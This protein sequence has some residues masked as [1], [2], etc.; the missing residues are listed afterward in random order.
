MAQFKLHRWGTTMQEV[1]NITTIWHTKKLGT[2]WQRRKPSLQNYTHPSI[3]LEFGTNLCLGSISTGSLVEPTWGGS[4]SSFNLWE[5]SL[6]PIILL[7][8]RERKTGKIVDTSN[9]SIRNNSGV[10]DMQR[11]LFLSKLVFFP[12]FKWYGPLSIETDFSL[13]CSTFKVINGKHNVYWNYYFNMEYNREGTGE[14]NIRFLFI[15]PF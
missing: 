13:W 6:P 1:P 4:L 2:E 15:S 3:K 9:R 10:C 11:V 12:D 5:K 14:C 8:R 7:W